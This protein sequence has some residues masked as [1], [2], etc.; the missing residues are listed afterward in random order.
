MVCEL[1][2]HPISTKYKQLLNWKHI[3]QRYEQHNA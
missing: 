2:K 1:F 3:N